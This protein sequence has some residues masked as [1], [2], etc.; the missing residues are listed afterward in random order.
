MDFHSYGWF[1]DYGFPRSHAVSNLNRDPILPRQKMVNPAA[2]HN[3]P[4]PLPT[5]QPLMRVQIAYDPPR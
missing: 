5:F 4:D 3:K 1:S 2:E